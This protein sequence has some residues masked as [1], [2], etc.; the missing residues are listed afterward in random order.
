MHVVISRRGTQM[1]A[2]LLAFSLISSKYGLANLQQM[3]GGGDD[4]ITPL[5]ENCVAKEVVITSPGGSE[6]KSMV[7]ST[8]PGG[9]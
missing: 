7:L 6:C 3:G 4:F 2:A 5:K 8:P 1:F 9:T